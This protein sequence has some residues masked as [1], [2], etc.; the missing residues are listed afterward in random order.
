MTN[1]L[2]KNNH[3]FTLIETFVAVTILVMATVGPLTIASRGLNS[4]IIARD[5]LTATY[6]AQEGLEEVRY[7]KDSNVLKGD[8]WMTGLDTCQDAVCQID[9]WA[10]PSASAC[11]DGT[12][13]NL[14]LGA[15]GKYRLQGDGEQTSF[16][17]EVEISDTSNTEK[18]VRV[19]V[20]WKSGIR[21]HEVEIRERMFDWAGG[22]I[23]VQP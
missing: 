18:L 7:I 15:D 3:G 16:I 8:D 23:K 17:R 9:V 20:T 1:L 19:T 6:L 2:A 5:Q 21:P 10:T 11:S 14:R 13:D 12:C 22:L 4:T